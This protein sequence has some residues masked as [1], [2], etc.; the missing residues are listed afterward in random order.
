MN[1]QIPCSITRSNFA[2]IRLLSFLVCL[3]Y[4]LC[5][6]SG[7]AQASSHSRKKPSSPPPPPPAA[8]FSGGVGLFFP[9]T[10]LSE[11]N[12]RYWF[13]PQVQKAAA[14]GLQF[15]NLVVHWKDLEPQDN[16]YSFDMLGRYMQVI[17]TLGLQ[18]VLRIYFNGGRHIQAS[19]D[20][21][22]EEKGG[23]LLPGRKRYPAAFKWSF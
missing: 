3:V 13:T 7:I 22:F 2:S 18:C 15:V 10:P 5:V 16:I 21:L 19:P 8:G 14:L 6:G 9:V 17:K 20:W 23:V 4:L 12:L 11:D 1:H